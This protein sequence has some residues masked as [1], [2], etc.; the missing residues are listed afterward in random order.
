[1]ITAH[2]RQLRG[3]ADQQELA[4]LHGEDMLQQIAEEITFTERVVTCTAPAGYQP[5]T[6]ACDNSVVTRAASQRRSA[7]PAPTARPA[8][9]RLRDEMMMAP[10]SEHLV[11][12]YAD[13]LLE[14]RIDRH[15]DGGQLLS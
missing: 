7:P 9:A 15:F 1:V 14:D 5:L 13:A 6:T 12:L 8:T 3:V 2:R 10:T 11:T 4:S